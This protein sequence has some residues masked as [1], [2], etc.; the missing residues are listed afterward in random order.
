MAKY[1][2]VKGDYAGGA[3]RIAEQFLKGNIGYPEVNLKLAG[4]EANASKDHD[5]NTKAL[6]HQMVKTIA[7]YASPY[8]PKGNGFNPI[9]LPQDVMANIANDITPIM[10]QLS[11]LQANNVAKAK[12]ISR[13]EKSLMAEM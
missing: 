10:Q 13:A 2:P 12:A 4:E 5:A 7:K 3:V 9:Q 8:V 6:I 1:E 11:T